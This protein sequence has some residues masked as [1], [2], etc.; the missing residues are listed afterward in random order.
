MMAPGQ[1]RHDQSPRRGEKWEVS[2]V[3]AD[4][5]EFGTMPAALGENGQG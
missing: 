5:E 4:T 3:L 1:G 2:T